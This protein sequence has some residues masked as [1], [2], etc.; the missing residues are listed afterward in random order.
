VSTKLKND[1]ESIPKMA[2]GEIALLVNTKPC[3]F[4]GCCRRTCPHNYVRIISRS[5]EAF[6][7]G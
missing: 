3:P 6:A 2:S 7:I 5:R 4:L 1:V